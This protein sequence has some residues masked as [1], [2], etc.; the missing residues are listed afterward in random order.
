M[1]YPFGV[2]VLSDSVVTLR[3]HQEQDVPRL[4]EMA[5]DPLTV[6]FTS[7]PDPYSMADAHDFLALMEQGWTSMHHRGWAIEHEGRFIG[8][9][10]IRGEV[11]PSIGFALH[12]DARGKSL[13]ARAV[14]LACTWAFTE[15]SASAIHWAANAGNIGSLR[16][17]H[18]TGFSLIGLIPQFINQRGAAVDAWVGVRK[19]GDPPAP[20]STWNKSVHLSGKSVRLRELRKS[21]AERIHQCFVDETTQHWLPEIAGFQLPQV[22]EFLDRTTFSQALGKK[23]AWAICPKDEDILIGFIALD[24]L[25]AP[26][27]AR[28]ELGYWMH[29]SYRGSG[30]MTEAGRL[31]L[32]HAFDPNGLGL[33][34]I[35]MF[36]AREN[37]ASH[38]VAE[39][40]GFA[41]IGI[42]HRAEI[43]GDGSES[44][45]IAWELLAKP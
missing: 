42:E 41:R 44:D 2:P 5:T 1:I 31:I 20:Q 10:D 15:G 26:G 30:F 11:T 29:P 25:D 19:F 27:P 6:R 7:V 40:L 36:S 24:A 23:V 18:A 4:F 38:R 8:N 33:V 13:M 17:A 3:A 16:V 12:P 35:A 34:R 22:Y 32:R 28:A 9:V 14:D 45:L 39:R 21:D 37:Q 43:L